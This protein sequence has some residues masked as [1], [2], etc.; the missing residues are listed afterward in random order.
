MLSAP[1]TA[2]DPLSIFPPEEGASAQGH[3][4]T[5]SRPVM[6][7]PVPDVDARETPAAP[8]IEVNDFPGPSAPTAVVLER[9]KGDAN[10][11]RVDLTELRSFGANLGR[12][13]TRLGEICRLT[14]SRSE[15]IIDVLNAIEKRIER[16]EVVR[17]LSLTTDEKLASLNRLVERVMQCRASFE[18]DK[19]AIDQGRE[20]ATRVARLMEGLH[21]RAARLTETGNWLGQAE[22]TVGRL[23][24]RFIETSAR[25]EARVND[26]D[27][28]TQ[29][30]EHALTDA[31][32]VATILA[33]VESRIAALTG[34][35]E[36][37]GRAEDTIG[38]L[39]RRAAEMTADI[40]RRASEAKV[41]LERVT[42]ATGVRHAA[43]ASRSPARKAGW[44]LL[45]AA[46]GV[47][48]LVAV[49][50]L[51]S[52]VPRTRDQSTE[53]IGTAAAHH[54]SSLAAPVSVPPSQPSRL[55]TLDLPKEVSLAGRPD[56]VAA[57]R[58]TR[59]ASVSQL[60]GSAEETVHYVG[61]LAV[62][63]Q[64]PG[65]VVFVDRQPVG[66]TPL[67]LRRPRAGPHVVRT[68]RDGYDRWTA[69]VLVSADRQTRVSARLEAVR[70][71]SHR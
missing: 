21:T 70:D 6:S 39:E 60:P 23:E 50:L 25:L 65:S 63:S 17:D 64:P 32:Q 55:A 53:I 58:T 56:L 22:Q 30:I 49:G 15:G 41:R 47:A 7:R 66:K 48:A 57:T 29:T 26:F 37:L 10:A 42:R 12:G 31:M 5:E 14:E 20:E 40:E 1:T 38:K 68:E 62:E 45:R 9:L 52:V 35:D 4:T 24:H 3:A 36:R 27:T 46:I 8:Q 33:G 18:A 13:Y 2:L 11:L 19:E 34:G 16:L 54:D 71:S 28:K 44:P 69:A 59:T 67:Q 43:E 51:G 61:S